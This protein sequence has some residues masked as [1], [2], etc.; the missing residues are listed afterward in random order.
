MITN[1]KIQ[2]FQSIHSLH[3]EMAP[4]TV[5]IGPS[6]SGKSAFV[7]ALRLLA[8]NSRG[9]SFISQGTRTCSVEATTA[10]GGHV[11]IERSTGSSGKNQYTVN[12]EKFTK[13]AGGVP[14]E[15]SKT[16][17]IPADADLN[18]AGQFDPPYL[19]G[20]SSGENAKI[21]GGLTNV[22][23]IFRGAQEANRRKLSS[24]SSLSTRSK[25]ATRLSESLK[26]FESLDSVKDALD[27][28]GEIISSLR[29]KEEERSAIVQA[30]QKLKALKESTR[31]ADADLAVVTPDVTNV[32]NLLTQFQ[33]L[34]KALS[35][36]YDNGIKVKKAK[37]DVTDL[38]SQLTALQHEYK[39]LLVEAGVCPVCE[40]TTD[41]LH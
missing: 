30:L 29:R 23:V 33:V 6:S 8:S 40:Q 24:S 3:L 7:R 27:T 10:L 9:T 41:H 26:E 20:T 37:S 1:I 32:E 22:D 19:L 12:G 25:D 18:F 28:S 31:Q 36:L 34:D 11:Q 16:L 14:E 4:F 38:D 5:I 13:L 21:L 15:A 39:D 17:G 2:N 35:S